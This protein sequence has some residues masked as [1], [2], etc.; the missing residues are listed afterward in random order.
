[1][2]RR[3]EEDA[4]E[5]CNHHLCC[6]IADSRPKVHPFISRVLFLV[7]ALAL[8]RDGQIYADRVMKSLLW[9]LQQRP[10]FGSQE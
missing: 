7:L 4:R 8:A 3:W 5:I 2:T 1:M 9:A 6:F 10:E